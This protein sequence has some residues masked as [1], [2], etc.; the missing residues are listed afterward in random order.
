MRLSLFRWQDYPAESPRHS[1]TLPWRLPD[2]APAF[3]NSARPVA[4]RPALIPPPCRQPAEPR[5]NKYRCQLPV[6]AQSFAELKLVQGLAEILSGD[7]RL[8]RGDRSFQMSQRLL[9]R[10]RVHLAAQTFASRERG[11]QVMPGNFYGQRIRDGLARALLVL[12]PRRV[13]QRHPN[14][15]SVDQK[16]DVDGIGV[17]RGDGHDHRLI[18]AMNLLFGPAVGSGEISKHRKTIADEGSASKF[19]HGESGLPAGNSSQHDK[20][21]RTRHD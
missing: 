16:L 15:F 17:T 10:E 21:F 6:P 13:A 12:H 20:W 4:P 19:R 18:H 14:R 1:R 5:N 11:L 3:L 2:Q 9:N 7:R 8:H